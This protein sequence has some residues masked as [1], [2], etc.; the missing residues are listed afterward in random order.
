MDN[1]ANMFSLGRGGRANVITQGGRT[2]DNTGAQMGLRRNWGGSI[3]NE[4]DDA[5]APYR[6]DHSAPSVSARLGGTGDQTPGEIGAYANVFAIEGGGAAQTHDTP[7]EIAAAVPPR[8][9]M[10]WGTTERRDDEN[11]ADI[12]QGGVRAAHRGTPYS[13]IATAIQ[14][15]GHGTPATM[16]QELAWQRSV[17]GKQIK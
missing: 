8:D 5:S 11:V 14:K 15:G 3:S 12:V 16:I 6:D 1:L 2:D 17:G 13:G 7:R 9:V 4:W 10:Q